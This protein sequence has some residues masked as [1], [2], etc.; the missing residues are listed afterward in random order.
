MSVLDRVGGALNTLLR[1]T[2]I[3]LTRR[4]V[5]DAERRTLG[6]V[7]QCRVSD[8]GF[9]E[10]IRKYRPH[11]P[12]EQAAD[13]AALVYS[14]A[15]NLTYR[16]QLEP[17]FGF[18]AETELPPGYR[19][20]DVGAAVGQLED[21]LRRKDF[22]GR[23]VGI[24]IGGAF[25]SIARRQC[26]AIEH[27]APPQFIQAD[28]A[29]LPFGTGVFE[30]V[31][32]RSTLVAQQDWKRALGEMTRV[33]A[34]WLILLDTPFHEGKDE[35]VYFMQFSKN[36]S[37]LLCSFT[38]D[39]F[40]RHLPRSAKVMVTTGEESEIVNFGKFRWHHIIIQVR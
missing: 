29:C 36:H 2:G 26:P 14:P 4:T 9:I 5:Y 23:Y 1:P 16:R 12:V 30:V 32:S 18:L 17:L 22:R 10:H 24:D 39:A 19:F 38:R 37:A 27:N 31:F 21:Q 34:K 25:L 3:R 11:P 33:A 6:R 7:V 15:W 40:E 20:L 35:T 28:A 13:L 8:E